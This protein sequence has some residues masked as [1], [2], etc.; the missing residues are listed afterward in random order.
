[1]ATSQLSRSLFIGGSWK[2]WQ[3]SGNICSFYLAV[4]KRGGERLLLRDSLWR[5]I[6]LCHAAIISYEFW[7]LSWLNKIFICVSTYK[8]REREH[9]WEVGSERG[10][11]DLLNSLYFIPSCI[12]SNP[13]LALQSL[14]SKLIL[15]QPFLKKMGGGL[16][17]IKCS[18]IIH[19]LSSPYLLT[20]YP[21]PLLTFST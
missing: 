9:I 17:I 10:G 20:D 2:F 7:I 14:K 19:C 15:T 12:R 3:E 21:L 5:T 6:S 8:E 4:K 11:R 13:Q 18:Q 1:M 16:W